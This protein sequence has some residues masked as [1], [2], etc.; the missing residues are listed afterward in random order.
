MKARGGKLHWLITPLLGSRPPTY[1]NTSALVHFNP[2]KQPKVRCG[3]VITKSVKL[4][5]DVICPDGTPAAVTIA[6]DHVD[7][8]LNGHSIVNGRTDE[9]DTVAVTDRR[10]VEDLEIRNGTISAGDKA[11]PRRGLG[12][13]VRATRQSTATSWRC[14]SHRRRQRDRAQQLP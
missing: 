4:D 9:G 10:P 6:A 11:M 8:D 1:G 14:R 2:V 3:D 5:A 13:R 7:L 12:Q